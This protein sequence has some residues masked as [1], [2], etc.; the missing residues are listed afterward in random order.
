MPSENLE[1]AARMLQLGVPLEPGR[2]LRLATTILTMTAARFG[3]PG[4]RPAAI[5]GGRAFIEPAV[6]IVFLLLLIPAGKKAIQFFSVTEILAQ[7]G[8]RVRVMHYV[9]AEF[10]VIR[11]YVVNQTAEKKNVAARA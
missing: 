9:L 7:E 8:G 10:F 5:P 1:N 11:E 2:I 4:L 6:R 3:V